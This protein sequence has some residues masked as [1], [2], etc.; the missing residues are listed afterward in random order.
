MFTRVNGSSWNR[1]KLRREQKW[2]DSL[3]E[4]KKGAM[5]ELRCIGRDL[6][7]MN[8]GSAKGTGGKVRY[9]NDLEGL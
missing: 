1:E 2:T 3:W 6:L 8:G 7:K 5:L 9:I 4:N